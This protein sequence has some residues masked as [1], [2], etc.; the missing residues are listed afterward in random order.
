MSEVVGVTANV[1]R[2]F[3]GNVFLPLLLSMEDRN[4]LESKH[5]DL[6]DWIELKVPASSVMEFM[7]G[8]SRCWLIDQKTYSSALYSAGYA[9]KGLKPINL[10]VA[11]EEM[12][13]MFKAARKF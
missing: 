2:M 6:S 3:Y 12:S 8:K 9:K 4:T 1:V 11:N 7:K 13:K 10:F 5:N